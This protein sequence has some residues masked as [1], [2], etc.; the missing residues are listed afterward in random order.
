VETVRLKNLLKWN[1][2][3]KHIYFSLLIILITGIVLRL[4]QIGFQCIWIDEQYTLS[5][6]SQ[7][8]QQIW[9]QSIFVDY[10]PPLFYW[11]DYLSITVFGATN[12]ALRLPSLISG[13]LLIPAMYYVGKTYNNYQTGIYCAAFTAIL[14]PLVYYSQYARAYSMSMLCFALVLI[15][16]IRILKG[17]IHLDTFAA[18]GILAG[19][20][21]WIHLYALI[22][23][24]FLTIVIIYENR[25]KLKHNTVLLAAYTLI[26]LP[27]YEMPMHFLTTR[28]SAFGN[29]PYALNTAQLIAIFPVEY[30]ST[31]FPFMFLLV[32]CGLHCDRKSRIMWEL[33]GVAVITIISGCIICEFTMVYAHYLLTVSLIFILIAALALPNMFNEDNTLN[34]RVIVYILLLFGTLFAFQYPTY[35]AQYT[36]QKYIC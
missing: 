11:L 32:V 24:A 1:P 12:V 27:L 30:F 10:T 33:F 3:S 7:S 22:P 31:A 8:V 21:V 23:L 20:T 4:Y 2:E 35:T 9:Y 14:Y 25:T 34:L 17:D 28:V 16:A 5:M 15:I 36:I 18:F 13:I 6:I 29:V 26:L 19:I